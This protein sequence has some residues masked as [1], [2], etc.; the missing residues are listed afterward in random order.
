MKTILFLCTGNS[1]RSIMAEAYMNHAGHG[2][3]RAYSAGSK[4]T[5]APN[6]F[7]IET[8]G[9]HDID[10]S[11]GGDAPRSKSWDEFAADGAPALDVVVTVCDNAAAETCP[12]WPARNGATPQTLHW[13]FPDPAAVDGDDDAKRTAFETVFKDI[14]ARIDAFLSEA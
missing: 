13:G 12:V 8:L 1:A 6:P 9:N 5:G 11:G 4:P 14:R 2:R 7:A 10:P 3:W